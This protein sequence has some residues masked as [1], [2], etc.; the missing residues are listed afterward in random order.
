MDRDFAVAGDPPAAS[1]LPAGQDRVAVFVRRDDLEPLAVG[2]TDARILARTQ[3]AMLIDDTSD[4]GQATRAGH[5]A[6]EEA[7]GRVLDRVLGL[8]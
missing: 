4:E 2:L 6:R 7:L 5:L 3:A 1:E 8:R